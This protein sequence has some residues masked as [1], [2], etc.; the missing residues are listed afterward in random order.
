M[1][2][3]YLNGVIGVVANDPLE[4]DL[5]TK[6]KL[7]CIEIRADLLINKGFSVDTIC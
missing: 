3:D 2:P 1:K 6:S 4:V 5:A 7:D